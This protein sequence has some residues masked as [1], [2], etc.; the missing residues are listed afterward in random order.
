MKVKIGPYPNWW[1]PHQIADK[2]MFWIPEYKNDEDWIKGKVNPAYEK[3]V[4]PLQDFL[5][6]VK[7]D[8]TWFADFCSWVHS[9]RKRTVKI[10]ID[11][12]DTWNM[13][14]TLAEIILPM[15]K[16][17]RDTKHGSPFVDL[18]DVPEE[19]RYTET[20]DHDSQ[21]CFPFYH[22]YDSEHT[23][24][25]EKMDC[26]V[27]TRWAWVLDEMIWAFE[28][29][30]DEDAEDK[31]HEGVSDWDFEVCAT[32]EDGS[33]KLYEMVKGPKHT[34]ETDWEGLKAHWARKQN[35]FRLFGKY[36]QGLWD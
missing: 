8:R 20:E 11:R 31:F 34:R 25:T 30:L 9:K 27:H 13:D 5:G 1:G 33:P 7:N 32:N 26:N 10:H 29:H 2:L 14:S 15:L 35:G 19:M 16:Q 24:I 23:E 22:Q 17:L 12:W 3:Y 21:A 18:E 4:E 28:T 36:Y 6:G